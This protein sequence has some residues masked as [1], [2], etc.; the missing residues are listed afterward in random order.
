[1]KLKEKVIEFPS[2]MRDK[3]EYMKNSNLDIL[4]QSGKLITIPL[5]N[6]ELIV[7]HIIIFKGKTEELKLLY[8][9]DYEEN[10]NS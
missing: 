4:Y 9:G 1:M 5:T 10:R 7:P 8:Y 2:Y 6:I 3:L